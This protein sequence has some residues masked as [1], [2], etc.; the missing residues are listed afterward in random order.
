MS[1]LEQTE[2][3]SSITSGNLRFPRLSPRLKRLS[4]ERL[5]RLLKAELD[6][7]KTTQSLESWCR[8]AL[9]PMGQTPA[10]HHRLLLTWLEA[11]SRGSIDRLMILMPPGSAKST[12]ASM[13]F[14]AWWFTQHPHS[15]VIV[16]SHTMEL[17]EKFG[18]RVRNLVL[19]YGDTLGYEVRSD[20]AAAGRWETTTGGEYFAAG[21]GSTITGRRA[22]LAIIDDPVGSRAD[23]E[24]ELQRDRVH[25]WYR[26]ELY[27]RLK[28]GGRILVIMT[29]WHE[30]DLGGRLLSEMEIGGDR[31]T[32]L[33]LPAIATEENDPLGRK[34]GEPLWEDWED[35]EKLQRKRLAVGERDWS[36]LYQQEPRPPEGSIFQVGQLG[37]P[38]DFPPSTMHGAVYGSVVRAWDL[39]ATRDMGTGDPD[40]TVGVKLMRTRDDRFIV[41]DVVRDRWGP[42]GVEAAIVA[43]AARDGQMVKIGIPQDP[44]QAG[45]AQIAYLSKK[46]IGHTI[47]SN[48]VSGDK[49]TRAAPAASQMNV[50]NVSLV[51]ATWNARFIDELAGFP[52]ASKDDQVDA[53]ALAFNML[54]PN[55]LNIW[56]KLA[57]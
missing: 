15:S 13:L 46:L 40:Y 43:T 10:R 44:G 25:D 6:R 4:D 41:L 48:P 24:S 55:K 28:P 27:T 1:T 20:S 30:D 34:P 12:Y 54:T 38:L 35:L 33:K 49:A 17:A 22:D 56:A 37:P 36:A 9:A 19:E 39:A 31:W 21:V 42:E 53:F 45:K 47:E 14:P 11:V 26:A 51:R 8:H 3:P 29:R 16:A 32:V 2:E 57:S 50:G 5:I 18:R 52:N 23:A 7:R